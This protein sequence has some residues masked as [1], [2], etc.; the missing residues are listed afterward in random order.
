LVGLLFPK[1]VLAADRAIEFNRDIGRFCLTMLSLPRV[2]YEQGNPV[3]PDSGRGDGRLR[4][5]NVPSLGT[6]IQQVVR[7]IT[8]KD[9]AVRMPPVYS[10]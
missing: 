4:R 8:A 7:R 3:A 2:R 9:E 6:G 10:V 5:Q 1:P